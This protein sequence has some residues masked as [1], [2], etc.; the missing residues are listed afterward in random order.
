MFQVQPVEPTLLGEASDRYGRARLRTFNA[1]AERLS[2]RVSKRR[3][4]E[5][6]ADP[7]MTAS[8]VLRTLQRAV[9]LPRRCLHN[10]RTD[11]C[12]VFFN[13]LG[14]S[15]N[16]LV[17]AVAISDAIE[18]RSRGR[19]NNTAVIPSAAFCVRISTMW[20]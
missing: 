19:N 12:G 10:S 15:S 6:T 13:S 7:Q 9:S 20:M 1:R 8:Q 3:R 2:R 18:L 11:V 4:A 16:Y 5:D 14:D 17:S